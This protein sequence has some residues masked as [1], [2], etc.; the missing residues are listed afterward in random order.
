[1]FAKLCSKIFQ[2]TSLYT[3]KSFLNATAGGEVSIILV[4]VSLLWR[5]MLYKAGYYSR[6]VVLPCHLS[7]QKLSKPS[8]IKKELRPKKNF[9]VAISPAQKSESS[10]FQRM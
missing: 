5:T 8:L 6:R 1:M 9:F 3:A 10:S 7:S 2:A 4:I